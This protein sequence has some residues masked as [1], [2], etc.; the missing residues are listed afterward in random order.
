MQLKQF[1]NTIIIKQFILF[2]DHSVYRIIQKIM[3][4]V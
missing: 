2:S 4:K 1:N 3:K